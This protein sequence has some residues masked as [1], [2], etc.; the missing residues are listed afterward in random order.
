MATS[1]LNSVLSLSIPLA[2]RSRHAIVIPKAAVWPA[3]RFP[4]R[5]MV[6]PALL[7][8]PFCVS[9]FAHG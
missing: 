4:L 3:L 8:G 1:P 7:D 9:C 2:Q 5:N 6:I